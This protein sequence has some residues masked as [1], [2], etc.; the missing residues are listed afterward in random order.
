ML[1]TLESINFCNVY[2]LPPTGGTESIGA[3]ASRYVAFSGAANTGN[4]MV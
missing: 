2:F 3:A 1:S 4:A